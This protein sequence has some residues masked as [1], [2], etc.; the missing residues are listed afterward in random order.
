MEIDKLRTEIRRSVDQKESLLDAAVVEQLSAVV[1]VLIHC[2]SKGNS[3]YW[4][5]NG[6]S[7][8]DAQHLAAELSGKYKIDRKPLPSESFT[9]NIAFLTAVAN[10]YGYERVFS[11]AVEAYCS[12]GDVLIGLSTSGQSSNV[13]KAV[14]KAEEMGVVTIAITGE[15][16]GDLAKY[17]RHCLRIP[18]GDTALIQESTLM[19][20]HILCGC[21]EEA[22]FKTND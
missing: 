22:L 13:V 14:L 7:A 11:R 20:G 12:P 15:N 1:E 2:L 3:V 18:S 16:G 10:D 5:G 9:T 6:G 21:I 4:C 8:S 19:L 17:A